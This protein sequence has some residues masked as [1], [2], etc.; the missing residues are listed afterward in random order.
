[1]NDDSFIPGLILGALLMAIF[2]GI[3]IILT[4]MN[5]NDVAVNKAMR[6]CQQKH[7]ICDYEVVTFPL[8]RGDIE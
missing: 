8:V 7:E 5:A 3:L 4:G 1:M 6:E 2:M